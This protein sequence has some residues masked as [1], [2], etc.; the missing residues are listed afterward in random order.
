M[1]REIGSEFELPNTPIAVTKLAGR[2]ERPNA[3]ETP[4]ETR[5]ETSVWMTKMTGMTARSTSLSA[6]SCDAS[7]VKTVY[8]VSGNAMLCAGDGTYSNMA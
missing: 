6:V 7:F 4:R 8:H 2:L 1:T 5:Y 3:M